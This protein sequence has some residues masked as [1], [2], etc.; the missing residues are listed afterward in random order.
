MKVECCLPVVDSGFVYFELIRH[1]LAPGK[2]DS[3][4]LERSSRDMYTSR[5]LSKVKPRNTIVTMP[6]NTYHTK[7]TLCIPRQ[8]GIAECGVTGTKTI[9]IREQWINALCSAWSRY[10]TMLMIVIPRYISGRLM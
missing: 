9:L 2:F 10:N 5:F 6:L 4:C 1:S 7:T 3:R 8:G